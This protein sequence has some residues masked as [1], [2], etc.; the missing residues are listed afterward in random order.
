VHEGTATEA[1]IPDPP[2]ST[3]PMPQKH[4]AFP[5]SA[6]LTA[7][8]DET[9]QTLA[10]PEKHHVGANE[11]ENSAPSLPPHQVSR[12]LYAAAKSGD[13]EGAKRLLEAN[14][15]VNAYFPGEEYGNV[16]QVASYMGHEAVVRLLLEKGAE[17]NAQGGIYG[18]AL[19]AASHVGHEAVVRLLLE[20]GADV[21]AEG[22]C[23]GNALQAAS[24]GHEAVVRLLLE[25]G[26]EVNAQGG[27]YGN[28]LNAASKNKHRAVVRL[29]VENGAKKPSLWK[30]LMDRVQQ[31]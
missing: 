10:T 26:A 3:L 19:Q 13:I 24:L 22:G 21:N 28:A 6:A 2:E 27:Y 31:L 5:S 1:E 30:S 17:V 11:A 9:Q 15:D 7:V 8:T 14:A 29:L 4:E 25:K 23:F 18:N 16:L 20:K 12:S